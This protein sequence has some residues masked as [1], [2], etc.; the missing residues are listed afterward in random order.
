MIRTTVVAI[1]FMTL[2]GSDIRSQAP[3][4]EPS[5]YR[6]EDYRAPTPATLAGARV[7]VTKE[8]EGLWKSG[9]VFVDVLAHAP[10][11][12]NL[13]AETIW[14]EKVRMNIP[15]SIWL[16]DTGYGAL[17]VETERYLRVGLDRITNG[18]HAKLVGC[19]GTPQSAR[20]P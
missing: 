11:P 2:I 15:G 13:P 4:P 3:P 9:T 17:A 5:G 10:R 12:A 8:A 20:S 14:R 19:R 7:I 1:G 16:P 6:I 18:D